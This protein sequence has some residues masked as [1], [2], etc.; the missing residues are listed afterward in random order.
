MPNVGRP[1]WP[2]ALQVEKMLRITA[3]LTKTER[4]PISTSGPSIFSMSPKFSMLPN[5][6]ISSDKSIRF[7]QLAAA[8]S[9]TIRGVG[10]RHPL[11][12]TKETWR[13]LVCGF[14]ERIS[15]SHCA[16]RTT[17]RQ[18]GLFQFLSQEVFAWLP[19]L[20]QDLVDRVAISPSS[21]LPDRSTRGSRRSAPSTS[22]SW[23]WIVPRLVPSGCSPISTDAFSSHPAWSNTTGAIA[24]VPLIMRPFWAFSPPN[25]PESPSQEVSSPASMLETPEARHR[26]AG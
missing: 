19:G 11:S 18:L 3:E 23:P 24:P 8:R 1:S 25:P 21:S 22:V 17:L 26:S 15:Y 16:I 13:P 9:L 20:S 7:S 14:V 6:A 4:D 5:Q 12:G 2:N 10:R